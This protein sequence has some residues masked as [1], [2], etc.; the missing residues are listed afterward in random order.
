MNSAISCGSDHQSSHSEQVVSGSHQIGAHLHPLA[1]P[2]AG[3][4]QAADGLHPAE[5]FLDALPK[6]LAHPV[7]LTAGGTG[8]EC[9][10]SW[11]GVIL[12]HVRGDIERATGRNEIASIVTLIAAQRDAAAARQPFVSHRDS[13]PALSEAVGRFDL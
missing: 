10:S 8:V 4:A 3:L 12:C 5:C 9:G 6:S 1:S 11:A 13:G 7:T 2:V